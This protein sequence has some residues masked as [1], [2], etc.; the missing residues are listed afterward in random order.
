M[1]E[2]RRSHFGLRHVGIKVSPV[3]NPAKGCSVW[4][5]LVIMIVEN[6]KGDPD[7]PNLRAADGDTASGRT[8]QSPRKAACVRVKGAGSSATP[9][10]PGTEHTA[11]HHPP[12]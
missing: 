9:D 8:K 2:E 12:V 7:P 1:S 5:M 11:P 3:V 6:S 10:L 4:I